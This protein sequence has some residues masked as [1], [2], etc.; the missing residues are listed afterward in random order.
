MDMNVPM[1]SNLAKIDWKFGV[2]WILVSAVGYAIAAMVPALFLDK[3]SY[4][5]F[6]FSFSMGFI[7]SLGQWLVLR[8]KIA[9]AVWWIPANTA[10][11]IIGA[12][13]WSGL[14]GLSQ[15]SFFLMFVPIGI[16]QWL[17]F[18]RK[19]HRIYWSIPVFMGTI[20]L[21]FMTA[22]GLL[23]Y[24]IQVGSDFSTMIAVFGVMGLVY[25]ILTA[26]PLILI[27]RKRVM[28]A[29]SA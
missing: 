28:C 16:L 2:R 10:G 22:G 5:D 6:V 21:A 27:L 4:L 24:P 1:E 12:K 26:C 7:G 23:L 11:W 13:V 18:Q 9:G 8:K 25:G 29:K 14:F 20:C 19:S 15:Y 17:V 3:P